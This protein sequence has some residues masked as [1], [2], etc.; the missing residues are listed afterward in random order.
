M[1]IFKQKLRFVFLYAFFTVLFVSTSLAQGDE[2]TTL[3]NRILYTKY[4]IADFFNF[5]KSKWL[6]ELDVVYRRQS[7]LG[8][9][10]IYNRP[11]RFSV[12]PWIAYQFTKMTRVSFQPFAYFQSAPRYA[13]ENALD[14]EF[15]REFRSTLQI[16][17]YAYYGRLNFTHRIRFESRWRGIDQEQVK[18]NFRARYRMR[19]RVPLNT[20]YFYTNNTIYSSIYSELHVEWGRDFGT[21]YLSQ[22]RSFA[23]L[24]YRF[25]NWARVE[26]GYLHQYNVRG[27]TNIVDL[28]RGPMFYFFLDFLSELKVNR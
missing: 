1:E 8:A 19:L 15:E 27:N 20:D 21:N 9:P 7:E 16:N 14:N 17:N 18:H 4:T 25:W 26:L 11:L 5:E 6:W 23:G 12:R 2:K 3:D 22:N 24:G 10:N 28:S 13:T